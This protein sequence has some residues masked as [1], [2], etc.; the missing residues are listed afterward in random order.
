V[1]NTIATNKPAL[2]YDAVRNCLDGISIANGYQTQPR[3]VESR[4][5]YNLE[6]YKHVIEI[7]PGD[8][9]LSPVEADETVALRFMIDQRIEIAGW[10]HGERSDA[11]DEFHKLLQDVLTAIHGGAAVI[12]GSVG[13]GKFGISEVQTDQS[14]LIKK[15]QSVFVITVTV[16]YYQDPTW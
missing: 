9:Y 6:S 11:M 5:A 14:T 10:A 2:V 12:C 15:D 4:D 7:Y 8:P 3:V 16:R 13:S 1:P